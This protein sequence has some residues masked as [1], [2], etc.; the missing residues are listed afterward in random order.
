MRRAFDAAIDVPGNADQT[1]AHDLQRELQ[2]AHF[3]V[4]IRDDLRGE[5]AGGDLARHVGGVQ[6]RLQQG[7]RQTPAHGE[8]RHHAQRN[9]AATQPCAPRV[10]VGPVGVQ[11]I[12]A[13]GGHDAGRQRRMAQHAAAH[14]TPEREC[15]HV[16]AATPA[17]PHRPS[18]RDA[19]APGRALAYARVELLGHFYL[20][21]RGTHTHR[22][23]SHHLA[24][25]DDGGCVGQHPVIA[26]V[27]APVL[28]DA[29]P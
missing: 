6:H 5:V 8:D 17:G 4:G 9:R 18:A 19:D 27:L 16:Q 2:A 14:A 3:V 23:I 1:L 11:A 13:R 7:T 22:G 10:Q 25:L 26:A 24:V 21:F 12:G 28:D 29:Q 15:Q 20:L